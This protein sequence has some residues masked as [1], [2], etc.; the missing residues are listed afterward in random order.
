LAALASL[1]LH[2]EWAAL[3]LANAD[4]EGSGAVAAPI[5]GGPNG[6]DALALIL[7]GPGGRAELWTGIPA[8]AR[9]TQS[10]AEAV[11]AE[12]ALAIPGRWRVVEW[13]RHA[14]GEQ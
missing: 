6:A 1:D 3:D 4:L 14:G 12:F 5:K 9:A 7:P 11:A 13:T 2:G 8:E 10:E